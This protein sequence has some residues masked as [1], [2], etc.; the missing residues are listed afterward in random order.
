MSSIYAEL[1]AKIAENPSLIHNRGPR[2]DLGVLLFNSHK[3]INELWLAS[4]RLSRKTT[5]AEMGEEELL[6]LREAVERLRVIFGERE[7][8]L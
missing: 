1:A 4:E 5:T 7:G 3:Y 6:A 2:S 8:R